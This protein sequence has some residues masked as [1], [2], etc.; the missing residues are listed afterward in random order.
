MLLTPLAVK[1]L[2]SENRS[3]FDA[4]HHPVRAPPVKA[5]KRSPFVRA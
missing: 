4:A 3:R 5:V 2:Q 1:A